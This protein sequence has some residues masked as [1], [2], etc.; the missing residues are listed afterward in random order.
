MP[1]ESIIPWRDI[2]REAARELFR[3]IADW[4]KNWRQR[5]SE[6]EP[7]IPEPR[8]G[9]LVIGPGGTGKS[10]LCRL[11]AGEWNWLLDDPWEYRESLDNEHYRLS[12]DPAVEI[13]V[14]PG[15][16]HRRESTWEE[17]LSHVAEGKYRGV[18]VTSAY[19]Y[20]SLPA[21]SYKQHPLYESDKERFLEA[22]LADRREDEIR[23]LRRLVPHLR[24]SGGKLW[25]LSVIGKEDLWHP[26]R[27]AV[28]ACYRD[29]EYGRAVSELLAG[30]DQRLLR[31]EFAFVSLVINNFD[32]RANERLR[33]NAAG[34]DHRLQVESVRRLFEFVAALKDWEG[35]A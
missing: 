24:M 3:S 32:T 4:F 28:E 6:A 35:R 7:P 23:V 12:D 25:V 31:H 18:I 5:K 1:E 30:R 33:K 22:Y 10:V 29:G 13:V 9:I 19:G 16:F 34:Y 26:D 27:V 8:P 17:L 15:Q 2:S 20:H 21:G 14:P 11:L